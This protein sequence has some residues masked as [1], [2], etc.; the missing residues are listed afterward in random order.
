MR[1]TPSRKLTVIVHA[2]VVGSTML[3]QKDEL[4]AHERIRAAFRALSETIDRYAGS[5][6]EIRGDALA[7]AAK[8]VAFDHDDSK[9]Q[10]LLGFLLQLNGRLDE[11]NTHLQRALH[12]NPNDADSIAATGMHAHARGR[13][14]DAINCY[15]KA[16]RLNPY[17]PVWYLWHLGFAYYNQKS[18]DKAL[19]VL[20]EANSRHPTFMFPRRALAATLAQLGRIDDASA[21]IERIIADQPGARISQGNVYVIGSGSHRD[22]WSQHWEAD[23]RKAGLPE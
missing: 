11:A 5:T 6:A 7:S 17:H 23:L 21:V 1:E 12:L 18:D 16:I 3:V 9:S 8:A 20:Q 22:I 4:L 15:L 13:S 10:Y 2:D 19:E 14:D